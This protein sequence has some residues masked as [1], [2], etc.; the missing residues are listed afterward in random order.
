M[1][2]RRAAADKPS[3]A[4]RGGPPADSPHLLTRTLYWR[5]NYQVTSSM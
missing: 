5:A 3:K 1:V 4:G 2:D